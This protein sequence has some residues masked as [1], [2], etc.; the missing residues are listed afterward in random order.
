MY[1]DVRKQLEHE[2]NL[3]KVCAGCIQGDIWHLY[4]I[5]NIRWLSMNIYQVFLVSLIL[6][7]WTWPG[8]YEEYEKWKP[9]DVRFIQPTKQ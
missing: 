1:D 8:T 9:G 4:L 7:N 6:G 3:R 2:K 5:V